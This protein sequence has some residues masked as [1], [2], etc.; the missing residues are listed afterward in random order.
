MKKLL[1]VAAFAFAGAI[2]A[3]AQ[4][5]AVVDMSYI[6]K[7]VPMY[8]SANE[9]LKQVSEKWQ[10]EVENKNNEAQ[11]LYKNYQTESVFY[12]DEMKTKK[13]NE[14]VAKEKEANDLKR[15]YFGPQ[16]ELFKKRESLMKPIQDEVYAAIKDV[17]E[18]NGYS[19]ILDKASAQNL[20]YYSSKVDIS[21]QILS[22]LGYAK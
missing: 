4:K 8:E 7:N 6:L 9:Q 3:V 17:A 15:K 22:K 5:T 12:S 11:V 13:E 10:K 16:G 1:M 20:I 21:D 19:I 18:K 14:I 2:S